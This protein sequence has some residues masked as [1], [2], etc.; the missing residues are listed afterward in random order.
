VTTVTLDDVGADPERTG[1]KGSPTIVAKT[2][3]VGEIG[4]SCTMHEGKAVD[5]LVCEV[6]DNSSVKEL[7]LASAPLG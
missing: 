7:L 1:L 4:G 2:E 3:K 6:I 5:E